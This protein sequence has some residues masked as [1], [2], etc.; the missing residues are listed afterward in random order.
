MLEAIKGYIGF[1]PGKLEC[2]VDGEHVSPQPGE[3][4]GGWVTHN[5]VGPMKGEPGTGWW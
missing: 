1:Y 5:I 4:Y 2:Y 3:F